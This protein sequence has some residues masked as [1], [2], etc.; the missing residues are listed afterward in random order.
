MV[1]CCFCRGSDLHF[2]KNLEIQVTP[3][4]VLFGKMQIRYLCLLEIDINLKH[5]CSLKSIA[6]RYDSADDG[7]LIA[8]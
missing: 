4:L 2:A 7:N 1:E 6:I 5:S 3:R 8:E